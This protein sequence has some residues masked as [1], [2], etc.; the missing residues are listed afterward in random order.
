MILAPPANGDHAEQRK[1]DPSHVPPSEIDPLIVDSLLTEH[2]TQ[3]A[4]YRQRLARNELKG[5]RNLTALRP[6]FNFYKDD[7]NDEATYQQVQA[8]FAQLY[9]RVEKT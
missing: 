7:A 2:A 1:L 8:T 4:H 3:I 9:D 6:K 5:H